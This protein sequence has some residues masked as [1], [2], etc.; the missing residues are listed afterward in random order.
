M[1]IGY[2]EIIHTAWPTFV[3]PTSQRQTGNEKTTHWNTIHD[4]TIMIR[5][6]TFSWFLIQNTS[7]LFM[8]CHSSD[9]KYFPFEFLPRILHLYIYTFIILFSNYSSKHQGKWLIIKLCIYH[10]VV[11]FVANSCKMHQA[12]STSFLVMPN[13]LITASLA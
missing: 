10:V 9:D 1:V 11:S 8:L 2:G 6:I 3:L 4:P 5:I 13:A 7:K 12:I